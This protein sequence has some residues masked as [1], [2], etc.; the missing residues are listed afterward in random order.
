MWTNFTDYT[1][2]SRC[3]RD[4]GTLVT[5]GYAQ[6]RRLNGDASQRRGRAEAEAAAH[7]VPAHVPAARHA[8]AAPRR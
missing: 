6:V 8:A 3:R 5:C 2:V 1:V 7:A 4:L